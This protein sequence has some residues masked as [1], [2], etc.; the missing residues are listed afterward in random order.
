MI[1]PRGDDRAVGGG[2]DVAQQLEVG[3]LEHAV[4]VHVGDD[5][6][7]AALGVEPGQHVVEVAALAGPAA[8]GQGAAADVE[9]DGDPV[10]VLRD[11]RRRTT[12]AAR[13][14]RCR[15]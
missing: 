7:R 1:P 6:A 4:L 5:V 2:A 11:R 10:A 14:R 13:A 15:C 12:R 3:A 8:G 9:P